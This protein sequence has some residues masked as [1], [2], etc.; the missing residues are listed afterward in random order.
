MRSSRRPR[1][2]TPRPRDDAR[3]PDRERADTVRVTGLPA[4]QALFAKRPQDVERLFFDARTASHLR[5]ACVALAQVRKPYRLV[6][7]DELA[8]VASTVLHGGVCAVARPRPVLRFDVEEAKGW[9]GPLLLL[10]GVGN[11]HNLGAIAR[12]AAFFGIGRIVLSDHPAQAGPSEA[13]YRVAEGGFEALALYRAERFVVALKRLQSSHLVIG[14]ALER[15]RPLD[16]ARLAAPPRPVALVL[17]NEEDGL[18]RATLD[19][20]GEIGFLPGTGSVQSLNV[21]ATAAILIH[22]LSLSRA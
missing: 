11:P 13:A 7:A 14:T 16:L 8:K 5:E 18:P 19:A 4:V 6:E 17:G 10:D 9:T 22:A 12:T 21:S 2:P 15:G 3:A 1:P 20:C